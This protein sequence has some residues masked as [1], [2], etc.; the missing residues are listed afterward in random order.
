MQV[1]AAVVGDAGLEAWALVGD[2]SVGTKV[3]I[4]PSGVAWEVV[5]VV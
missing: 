3:G 4:R 1:A 5:A 2:T